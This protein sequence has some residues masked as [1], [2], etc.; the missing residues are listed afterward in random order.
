MNPSDLITNPAYSWYPANINHRTETQ[1]PPSGT[2]DEHTPS[3]DM[4]FLGGVMFFVVAVVFIF[5]RRL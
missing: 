2:P 5:G 3:Q 4:A 1:T